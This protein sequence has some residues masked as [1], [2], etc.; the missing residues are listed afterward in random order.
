MQTT[1]TPPLGDTD[2]GKSGS[3][4]CRVPAGSQDG[5]PSVGSETTRPIRPHEAGPPAHSR[6]TKPPASAR[7]WKVGSWQ[8]CPGCLAGAA[9]AL[10]LCGWTPS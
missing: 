2:H 8:P 5:R 7:C 9:V 6:R 4:R 3:D 1:D 10:G